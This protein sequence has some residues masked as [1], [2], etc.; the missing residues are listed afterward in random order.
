MATS[1]L[2][3]SNADPLFLLDKNIRYILLALVPYQV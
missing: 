3:Y 2:I 1:Y